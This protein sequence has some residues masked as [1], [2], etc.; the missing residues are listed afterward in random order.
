MAST[1]DYRRLIRQAITLP[2]KKRTGRH[3]ML[4]RNDAASVFKAPLFGN[5]LP[6]FRLQTYSRRYKKRREHFFNLSLPPKNRHAFPTT[7]FFSTTPLCL[8]RFNTFS[9]LDSCFLKSTSRR[10]G[11]RQAG[12]LLID[13]CVLHIISLFCLALIFLICLIARPFP[14]VILRRSVAMTLLFYT[15]IAAQTICRQQ[16]GRLPR[17]QLSCSS[18][19]RA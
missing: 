14:F 9:Q 6:P 10:A 12:N 11:V 3:D 18:F 4:P 7:D 15:A 8:Y 2:D 1:E 17:R 5:R 16:P 13:R 19:Y